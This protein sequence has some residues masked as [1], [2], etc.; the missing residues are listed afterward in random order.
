MSA[1]PNGGFW[2]PAGRTIIDLASRG[3]VPYCV[4]CGAEKGPK[5]KR[6]YCRVQP[7]P[8]L[9][10]E[11]WYRSLGVARRAALRRAGGRCERCGAVPTPIKSIRGRPWRTWG[12]L[13]VD[14]KIEVAR[15]GDLYNPSNFQVLCSRCHSEKT[16]LF[17]RLGKLAR[18][19]APIN[20]VRLEAFEPGRA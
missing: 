8:D 1:R 9:F 3:L 5:S 17:M 6:P 18:H 11:R 14:H 16:R 4:S 15:G 13:E 12:R 10:Y 2:A 19:R 7:C 20:A